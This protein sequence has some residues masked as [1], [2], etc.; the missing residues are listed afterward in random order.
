LRG[1]ADKNWIVEWRSLPDNYI[2]SVTTNGEK[3]VAMREEPE[4]GVAGL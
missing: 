3:P 2:I 1:Y 4:A